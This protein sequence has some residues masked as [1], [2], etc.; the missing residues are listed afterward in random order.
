M[1]VKANRSKTITEQVHDGRSGELREMSYTSCKIVGSGS[2]GIVFQ[3]KLIDT[4]EDAAIK[5]VL[6][7]KRFKVDQAHALSAKLIVRIENSKS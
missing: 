4:N 2:F 1:S 3:T 6:Q 5:R 7:D